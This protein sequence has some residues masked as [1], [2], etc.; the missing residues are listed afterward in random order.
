M[1]TEREVNE[2]LKAFHEDYASLRRYL[3]DTGLLNRQVVRSVDKDELI[4]GNPKLDLHISY[5]RPKE[6]MAH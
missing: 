4:Q 2:I 1:Y 3:I 6:S 5:W